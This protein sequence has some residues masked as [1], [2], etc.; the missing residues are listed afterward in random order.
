MSGAP[1]IFREPVRWGDMDA[2]GHVNNTLYFRYCE[3]ARVAYFEA[4]R[5]GLTTEDGAE[6]ILLAAASLNFRRSLKYPD[7]AV[8]EVRA[9]AM[10]QRSIT[11]A[12]TLRSAADGSVA[13]DGTS[14]VVWADY[15]RGKA[16]PLPDALS[17]AIAAFEGRSFD[18]TAGG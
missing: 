12:Y 8:V 16:I 15:K 13:A 6:G 18:R 11:M 5:G 10:S 17:A 9:T 2:I 14:V 7:A 3:S 4:L 1:F